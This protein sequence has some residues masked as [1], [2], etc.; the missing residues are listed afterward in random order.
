MTPPPPPATP[1]TL[2]ISAVH[3]KKTGQARKLRGSGKDAKAERVEDELAALG[4]SIASLEAEIR[5]CSQEVS[6]QVFIARVFFRNVWF[7][8]LFV[9]MGA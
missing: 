8:C 1:F 6:T 5:A 2:V 4:E 7:V 3:A 9:S